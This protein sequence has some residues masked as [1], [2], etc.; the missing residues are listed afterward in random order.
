MFQTHRSL[1]PVQP[2]AAHGEH[3]VIAVEKANRLG[4]QGGEDGR[5]IRRN[6]EAAESACASKAGAVTNPPGDWT[7]ENSSDGEA[8]DWLRRVGD[9]TEGQTL[10]IECM[11]MEHAVVVIVHEVDPRA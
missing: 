3:E 7:V 4:R 10:K 2:G 11:D 1:G 6:G 8:S 9:V 5:L